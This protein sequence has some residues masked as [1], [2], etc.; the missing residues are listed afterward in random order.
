MGSH[1]IRAN[2]LGESVAESVRRFNDHRR[3]PAGN[4]DRH[5]GGQ[6]DGTAPR[7]TAPVDAIRAEVDRL[8]TRDMRK[9]MAPRSFKFQVP[10]ADGGGTWKVEVS[11]RPNGRYQPVTTPDPRGMRESKQRN[12][13]AESSGS[14]SS[15]QATGTSGGT[16]GPSIGVFVSPFLITPVDTGSVGARL[17]GR[18]TAGWRSR[19]VSFSANNAHGVQSTEELKGP[20]HTYRSDMRLDVGLTPPGEERIGLGEQH[21][22]VDVHVPGGLGRVRPDAPRT[23]TFADPNAP[24]F[25][26]AHQPFPGPGFRGATE[27]HPIQVSEPSYNPPPRDDGTPAPGRG[28]KLTEWTNDHLGVRP[29][30]TRD[31]FRSSSTRQGI[32]EQTAE[33]NANTLAT[34]MFRDNIARTTNGPLPLYVTDRYGRP[35]IMYVWSFPTRFELQ[36]DPPNVYDLRSV[37]GSTKG[38]ASGK[39]QSSFFRVLV[40]GGLDIAISVLDFIAGRISPVLVEVTGQV[41]RHHGDSRNQSGSLSS[42]YWGSADTAVYRVS[43][44]YYVQFDGEPEMHRF[45]GTTYETTTVGNAKRLHSAENPAPA[46]PPA[47]TANTDTATAA[48]AAG[49]STAAGADGGN[50]RNATT[51]T[52]TGGLPAALTRTPRAEGR[53]RSA[54]RADNVNSAPPQDGDRRP[55]VFRRPSAYT[56]GDGQ[57]FRKPPNSDRAI[58]ANEG[59]IRKVLHDLSTE[60]AGVVLPDF[61]RNEDD[62]AIKPGHEDSRWWQRSVREN[63][64]MRRSYETALENTQ[65][66]VDALSESGMLGND[67]DLYSR[68]GLLVP[69]LES[70]T[71]KDNVKAVRVFGDRGA[72]QY[73][74]PGDRGVGLES[75]SGST[76]GSGKGR[77]GSLAVSPQVA[78]NFMEGRPDAQG[79]REAGLFPKLRATF[80]FSRNE[81]TGQAASGSAANTL[82]FKG[83]T[84]MWTSPSTITVRTYTGDDLGQDFGGRSLRDRGKQ[85]GTPETLRYEFATP[86]LPDGTTI[87]FPGDADPAVI[88]PMDRGDAENQIK[89]AGRP[90]NRPGQAPS[91]IDRLRNA[92]AAITDVTTAF[93]EA[94]PARTPLRT[95]PPLRQEQRQDDARDQARDRD[96]TP[97]TAG[98]DISM[99]EA[100]YRQFSRKGVGGRYRWG[101]GGKGWVDGYTRKVRH[102]VRDSAAGRHFFPNYASPANMAAHIQDGARAS[103]DVSSRLRSPHNLRTTTDTRPEVSGVKA[104]PVQAE[105]ISEDSDAPHDRSITNTR[106]ASAGVGGSATARINAVND[107]AGAPAGSGQGGSPVSQGSSQAPTWSS[108]PQAQRTWVFSSKGRSSAA[109]RSSSTTVLPSSPRAYLFQAAGTVKQAT[110]FARNWSIG[111]TINRSA[112]YSGWQ[113]TTDNLYSGFMHAWGA[114]THGLVDDGLRVERNGDGEVTG[115]GRTPLEGPAVDDAAAVRIRPGFEGR[116]EVQTPPDAGPAL[117]RLD[118]N[119]RRSHLELTRNSREKLRQALVS[120]LADHAAS[121]GPIAVKV[122]RTDV[123]GLRPHGL[124][125]AVDAVVDVDVAR[126]DTRIESVG[127]EAE[128]RRRYQTKTSDGNMQGSATQNTAGVQGNSLMFPTQA[129]PSGDGSGTMPDGAR[130]TPYSTVHDNTISSAQ[131]AGR[132]ITDIGTR[133]THLAVVS[134]YAQVSQDTQVTLH[135]TFPGRGPNAWA[136]VDSGVRHNGVTG[137]GPGGRTYATYSAHYLEFRSGEPDGGRVP[138]GGHPARF[139]EAEGRRP[140]ERWRDWSP[141]GTR[142]GA[143]SRGFVE[144]IE[145]GGKAVK[146]LAHVGLAAANGWRPGVGHRDGT[147]YTD[148]GVA[149]ARAFLDG[150]FGRDAYYD[151]VDDSLTDIALASSWKDA[152]SGADGYRPPDV[153]RTSLALKAGV[154]RGAGARV[155]DVA[156]TGSISGA[157]G[158]EHGNA[159]P[160]S[161]TSTL[162]NTGGPSVAAEIYATHD[163]FQRQVVDYNSLEAHSAFNSGGT[164]TPVFTAKG[165]STDKSNVEEPLYLVEFDVDWGAFAQ[166]H[167]RSGEPAGDSFMG[168]T[169]TRQTGWVTQQDALDL[170]FITPDTIRSTSSGRAALLLGQ[171]DLRAAEDALLEA[172]QSLLPAAAQAT[173]GGPGSDDHRRY[174]NLLTDYR[175]RVDDYRNSLN[176]W[177]DTA[178]AVRDLLAPAERPQPNVQTDGAER[179]ETAPPPRLRRPGPRGLSTIAEAGE[180][181]EVEG[182][183]TGAPIGPE[184]ATGTGGGGLRRPATDPD[185]PGG[186]DQRPVHDRPEQDPAERH[187]EGRREQPATSPTEEARGRPSTDD[188]SVRPPGDVAAGEPKGRPTAATATGPKTTAPP[189]LPARE[190]TSADSTQ[191]PSDMP[192]NDPE[193]HLHAPP[194]DQTPQSSDPG[195]PTESR[196]AEQP[197]TRQPQK[198]QP[199]KQSEPPEQSQRSEQPGQPESVFRNGEADRSFHRH[200]GA[201]D[202]VAAEQAG[203]SVGTETGRPPKHG[204]QEPPP[205]GASGRTG[206]RPR[207]EDAPEAAS[208]APADDSGRARSTGPEEGGDAEPVPADAPDR[209]RDA[210]GQGNQQSSGRPQEDGPEPG[211]APGPDPLPVPERFRSTSPAAAPRPPASP[212]RQTGPSGPRTSAPVTAAAPVPPSPRQSSGQ[213]EPE[214]QASSDVRRSESTGAQ[215]AQPQGRSPGNQEAGEQGRRRQTAGRGAQEPETPP[216][217]SDLAAFFDDALNPGRHRGGSTGG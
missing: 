206:D 94:G 92:G 59:L 49:P 87:G 108:G 155:L 184:D 39:S 129:P 6:Q 63:P 136:Q 144:V 52:D 138:P 91:Y 38:V 79:R 142:A 54:T 179:T 135:L 140:D 174:L 212:E 22:E 204:V 159:A 203:E 53:E 29:R 31:Y 180:G 194:D 68:D 100:T 122:R 198:S 86:R 12:R 95:Q 189:N 214:V 72:A 196:Q 51:G 27:T 50:S 121:R 171:E 151:G 48:A 24:G 141:H 123:G 66:I 90:G 150:E 115:L 190:T 85:L 40:G 42:L 43:R 118:Q 177:R 170:G 186:P 112:V 4:T 84:D 69:L 158:A 126:T 17:T 205:S 97:A 207:A 32:A 2:G 107:P 187:R 133:S 89:S 208:A 169:R 127:G 166:R 182:A 147:A 199:S 5:G 120:D 217:I 28:R 11:L 25:D 75:K 103:T 178:N 37:S 125:P 210:G 30:P 46:A 8:S 202:A 132:A 105:I 143:A 156:H 57:Y 106:T 7:S 113:A 10:G 96:G 83:A 131:G 183:A 71:F 157:S 73:S 104:E 98:R 36:P 197:E 16:K 176:S 213:S 34:D 201:S 145:N 117:T 185:G 82:Q 192:H 137:R 99:T 114:I 188:G 18:I 211:R 80:G 215:G 47:A 19:Q 163:G 200:G 195:R 44:N 216:A 175:G 23:I 35:R 93:R 13:I 77:G 74:G 33:D 102:M 173:R 161:H 149:S 154:P 119:L 134:P 110:E 128:I 139:P 181:G 116:G 146:D 55:P 67:G 21:L 81:S 70:S 165:P 164:D 148:A 191:T 61:S 62:F 167:D 14:A 65:R 58:T 168:T 193:Q 78:G 101:L 60:Y 26:P 111:P 41:Q 152:V 172:R 3:R 9:V 162:S 56:W 124:T 88:R 15:R 109:S 1:T 76:L 130:P 160:G 20:L 209:S 153:G 45:Q 64:P